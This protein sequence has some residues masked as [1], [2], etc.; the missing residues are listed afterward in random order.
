M[1]RKITIN[2]DSTISS[3]KKYFLFVFK[4]LYIS[5][6]SHLVA[7]MFASDP[8]NYYF[9]N[10]ER[11]I[12]SYI[13]LKLPR[14]SLQPAFRQRIS[15]IFTAVMFSFAVELILV[16]FLPPLLLFSRSYSNLNTALLGRVVRKLCRRIYTIYTHVQK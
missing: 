2:N 3:I 7:F 1:L 10:V 14:R 16:L 13:S 11:S 12:R 5:R 15:R 6:G 9:N 8:H 4:P